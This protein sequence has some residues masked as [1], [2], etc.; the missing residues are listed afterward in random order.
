MHRDSADS[1]QV[2]GSKESGF[3][4]NYCRCSYAVTVHPA[5]KWV[6][7]VLNNNFKPHKYVRIDWC[8]LRNSGCNTLLAAS[9][10]PA[11]G[12]SLL[13]TDSHSR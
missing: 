3:N 1:V 5:L 8:A 7:Q 13:K 10:F 2:E 9:A 6:T 4:E 12:N 11:I